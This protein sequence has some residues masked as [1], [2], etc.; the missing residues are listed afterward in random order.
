MSFV[1]HEFYD[2]TVELRMKL[3]EIVYLSIY[4]VSRDILLA[5]SISPYIQSTTFGRV[6]QYMTPLHVRISQ[7]ENFRLSICQY[8]LSTCVF[9][10]LQLIFCP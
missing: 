3:K 2:A 7:Y 9:I 1:H 8:I 10:L 5:K 6:T 4:S